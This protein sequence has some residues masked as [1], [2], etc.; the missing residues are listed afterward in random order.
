MKP[1][2]EE[3][4]TI[5]TD[6]SMYSKPTRVGGLG[7]VFVYYLERG[8]KEIT[9]EF[10]YQGY[11]GATNNQMELLACVYALVEAQ[12]LEELN[13]F[14]QIDIYTDSRYVSENYMKAMFMWPKAHWVTKDGTPVLNT[15][16]WKDLTKQIKKVNKKVNIQWVKGHAKD[17]YNKAAD[18]LA[19]KSAK[20]AS[21]DPLHYVDLR[22]KKSPKKTKIQSVEMKGQRI[23]IRIITCEY[24]NYHKTFKLRYEVMSKG[25]KYYQNVDFIYSKDALRTGRTYQVVFNR[26]TKYPQIV[27]MVKEIETK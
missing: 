15:Q 13:N 12:N 25:S 11:K 1:L 21:N 18:R 5:Y 14:S 4:L 27:R 6:G 16:E 3:N 22:R 19:K 9:K 2:K 17:P 20:T 23:I 8:T 24:L 10:D 7:F 26:D